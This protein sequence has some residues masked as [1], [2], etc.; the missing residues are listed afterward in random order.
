MA[1]TGR[2]RRSER[3]RRRKPDLTLRIPAVG[4]MASGSSRATERA[5]GITVHTGWGACVVV[6]GS[7]EKPQI[8]GNR[9][10]D[11]VE[12]AERFCYHRA[13]EM[14]AASVRDWLAR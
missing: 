8:I 10:I 2:R 3:E 13:A 1:C 6:G 14:K 5:I 11:L 4:C 9:V 12:G 7:L